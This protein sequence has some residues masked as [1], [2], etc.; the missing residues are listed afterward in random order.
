MNFRDY[1]RSLDMSEKQEFA[2]RARTSHKY[3][4]IHLQEPRK[5][6]SLDMVQRLVAASQ[7]AVSLSEMVEH[8]NQVR[9]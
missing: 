5:K 9:R 3:C 2:E 4:Y 8:F 7:G 1:Y 6:A